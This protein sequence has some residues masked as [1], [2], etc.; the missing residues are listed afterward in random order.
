M[1][2]IEPKCLKLFMRAKGYTCEHP[3]VLNNHAKQHYV[4]LAAAA[5]KDHLPKEVAFLFQVLL[6]V[7]LRE[8]SEFRKVMIRFN[9]TSLDSDRS[10]IAQKRT[11]LA[12]AGEN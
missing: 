12:K 8:N 11:C 6:L 2:K 5:L 10:I 7:V 1:L 4:Y 9:Y 3:N